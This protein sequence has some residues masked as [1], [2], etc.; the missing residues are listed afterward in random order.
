MALALVWVTLRRGCF[1]CYPELP[2]ACG[3]GTTTLHLAQAA[4]LHLLPAG[5]RCRL[6]G[7]LGRDQDENPL[8]MFAMGGLRH[9]YRSQRA[10]KHHRTKAAVAMRRVIGTWLK[11]PLRLPGSAE[12]TLLARIR[13]EGGAIK[14]TGKQ[15][16]R[17]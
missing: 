12:F 10:D 5:T 15:A 4:T 13:I 16:A 7:P 6:P 1:R 9:T 14:A 2:S 8:K 17:A 11:F 3:K